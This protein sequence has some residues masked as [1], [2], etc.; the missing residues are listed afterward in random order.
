MAPVRLVAARP[1][2]AGSRCE[3]S[4]ELAHL[5]GAGPQRDGHLSRHAVVGTA[6]DD[7]DRYLRL[8][9]CADLRIGGRRIA[10]A[11]IEDRVPDRFP[12]RR[13]LPQHAAPGAAVSLVLRGAG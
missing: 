5:L 7:R 10:D 4:L 6:V 2:W 1:Q 12:L 13:I 9:H 8:D 3:L 11:A